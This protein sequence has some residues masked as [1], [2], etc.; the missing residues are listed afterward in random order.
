MSKDRF[1]SAYF[2]FSLRMPGPLLGKSSPAEGVMLVDFRLDADVSR[3]AP[4]INA[5]AQKASYYEKPPFIRFMLDGYLC[6]L[7]RNEGSAACFS[8]RSQALEFMERLLAFLN[9]LY[10]R[11]DSIEPNH[12]R[13]KPISVLDILKLLPGVN[14]GKCGFGACMAFAAALSRRKTT[15]HGCPD[16]RRPIALNAVYP[17]FDSKGNLLSTVSID[18]DDGD[19]AEP[20]SKMTSPHLESPAKE[21][22]EISR[23]GRTVP[24]AGND[25]L[26]TPLTRREIEVLRLVAQGATNTEI[27]DALDISP[28]T[29]KS[30][31]IHIFNKLG[32]ND[33]TQ[34]AVWAAR[35]NIIA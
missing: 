17:V 13:Y 12:K 16:F 35:R 26:P 15:A 19:T 29:V 21:T 11:R 27:S 14:C 1:V 4:Y 25:L 6:T 2:D 31:I 32:V 10:L 23:P 5:V 7:H 24:V 30:H 8:D 28:H 9:D 33:R 18:I 22:P 20:P 34:A 3:L